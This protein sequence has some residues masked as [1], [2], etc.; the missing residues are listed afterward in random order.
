MGMELQLT[1]GT[2]VILAATY[3]GEYEWEN[4]PND[5]LGVYL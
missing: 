1:P 2:S 3:L 5:S 4:A